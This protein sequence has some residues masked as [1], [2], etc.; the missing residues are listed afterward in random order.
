MSPHLG[1]PAAD[2]PICKGRG[3]LHDLNLPQK[4]LA[5]LR[6][7]IPQLPPARHQ[8]ACRS[9]SLPHLLLSLDLKNLIFDEGSSLRN[10]AQPSMS[11]RHNQDWDPMGDL[12]GSSW[13]VDI[14]HELA[15]LQCHS[16]PISLSRSSLPHLCHAIFLMEL[17]D[18]PSWLIPLQ[19]SLL[20]PLHLVCTIQLP[21]GPNPQPHGDLIAVADHC[22]LNVLLPSLNIHQ[23]ILEV[24][25][26]PQGLPQHSIIC[27]QARIPPHV[28]LMQGQCSQPLRLPQA[29]LTSPHELL[30][31]ILMDPLLRQGVP[32]PPKFLP[33]NLNSCSRLRAH[34]H[35]DLRL[36]CLRQIH[37]HEAHQMFLK[38]DSIHILAMKPHLL[39]VVLH[40]GIQP[41]QRVF[42]SPTLCPHHYA[43]AVLAL[44]QIP[45]NV[46]LIPQHAC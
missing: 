42:P 19:C 23:L 11:P 46:G 6:A 40:Q 10:V 30:L 16:E 43:C 21:Q 20:H 18:L 17:H 7:M 15:Q 38:I 13:L 33:H 29:N 39:K 5:L 8:L 2:D 41:P 32:Q 28:F 9:P 37:I 14:P 25:L 44:P 3:L 35:G 34:A 27:L 36:G 12:N 26:R 45:R 1:N 31:P 22:V 24:H 4:S